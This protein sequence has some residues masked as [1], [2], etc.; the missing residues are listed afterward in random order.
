[1]LDYAVTGISFAV[2]FDLDEH[3]LR[4]TDLKIAQNFPVVV[5]VMVERITLL[6]VAVQEIERHGVI[7]RIGLFLDNYEEVIHRPIT[8]EYDGDGRSLM[9]CAEIVPTNVKPLG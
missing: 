6:Q 5:Q 2:T 3:V 7:S 9:T 4:H 1:M 8:A